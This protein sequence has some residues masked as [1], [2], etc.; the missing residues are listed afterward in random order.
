[1][2]FALFA[3]KREESGTVSYRYIRA[4]DNAEIEGIERAINFCRQYGERLPIK[5]VFTTYSS[6]CELIDQLL[7]S[8][9][10][11]TKSILD[12]IHA[13]VSAFCLFWTLFIDH[14][15]ADL[16]SRFGKESG[17]YLRFV[18]AS[19]EAYD[20]HPGYRLVDG[21][22]NY[23]QHVGLPNIAVSKQVKGEPPAF[24]E[25]SVDVQVSL[26]IQP[27]VAALVKRK[28]K[29]VLV[30][31]LESIS[32]D[33]I[34]LVWYLNDAMS[35]FRYLVKVLGEI[36]GPELKQSAT[37]LKSV[38]S[39]TKGEFPAIQE[40]VIDHT[41]GKITSFNQIQFSDVLPL[42]TAVGEP[43]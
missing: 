21:L 26:V 22:R 40:I 41:S 13:Q 23:V 6:F 39:E 33:T 5:I 8:R 18:R 2:T 34:D 31:D 7:S 29:K 27:L 1:M 30:A 42:V 43:Q 32:S 4:L 10:L 35:G 17:A 14:S 36:D 24:A 25:A 38:L 12:A 11:Q 20:R 37:L 16:S 19:N 9:E 28:E 15:K 3:A